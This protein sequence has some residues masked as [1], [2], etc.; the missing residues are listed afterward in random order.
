ME[1]G[2]GSAMRGLGMGGYLEKGTNHIV[3]IETDRTEE[4]VF[5]EYPEEDVETEPE[6]FERLPRISELYKVV[7]YARIIGIDPDEL[8]ECGV[9]FGE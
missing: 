8:L 5:I 1:I 6:R 9:A 2:L 4:G 3:Q 7:E